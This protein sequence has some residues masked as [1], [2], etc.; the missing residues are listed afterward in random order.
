MKSYTGSEHIT[1]KAFAEKVCQNEKKV[2][3]KRLLKE[4]KVD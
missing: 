4:K 2:V 3:T 1:E